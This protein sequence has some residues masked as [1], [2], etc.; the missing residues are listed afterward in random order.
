MLATLKR[1]RG[2][3]IESCAGDIQGKLYPFLNCDL[4]KEIRK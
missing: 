3:H 2:G 1:C 4:V